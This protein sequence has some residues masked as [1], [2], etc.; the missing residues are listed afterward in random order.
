M[1]YKKFTAHIHVIY[2][3]IE[4]AT[5]VTPLLLFQ[6]SQVILAR[7]FL[8]LKINMHFMNGHKYDFFNEACIICA[9]EPC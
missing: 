2:K 3:F 8:I 4:V 6:L 5:L 1:L 7:L 9:V